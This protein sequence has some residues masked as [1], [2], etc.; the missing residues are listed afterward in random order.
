MLP[1][2]RSARL[3]A[4]VTTTTTIVSVKEE[5][6]TVTVAK[7]E[8]E[9]SKKSAKKSVSVSIKEEEDIQED[10]ENIEPIPLVANIDPTYLAHIPPGPC[11]LSWTHHSAS[12]ERCG[13]S[14]KVC[15]GVDEAGRGP[16]LGPMVYAVAYMPVDMKDD[17]A[18]VGFADS[19][20]LKE[21]Q[22]DK[23]FGTLQ[24][25][26]DWI[27][28]AVRVCS[29]QDISE[30]MLR[31]CKHN[32]NELAHETTMDLIAETLQR[33]IN[34]AEVYVDTVGPPDSYK[35]KLQ[36]RFPQLRFTVAKKADSL[37]PCVSAASICAKVTRDAVL[38]QWQYVEN[39]IETLFS[40][41]FGSGYPS[42]P[43]TVNWMNH[44]IDPVFGYPRIVRFSWATSV[45]LLKDRACAVKWPEE[46][47]AAEGADIRGYFGSKPTG[48]SSGDS[49]TT[50]AK[51]F[52]PRDTLLASLKHVAQFP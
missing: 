32:L 7:Q 8:L 20:L 24:D 45:N 51:A 39:N 16:V 29:P 50:L 34:V 33:G 6:S 9:G 37:Y 44:H 36:A 3:G 1:Q 28:W 17:L 47:E 26:N 11:T 23:L 5:I 2:R 10:R 19:K 13:E 40:N 43:N 15:L 35:R 30:A 14:M 18:N 52:P 12:P 49:G 31:R 4:N 48:G 42:D 22:R 27:G 38:K 41:P 21:E 25:H 46:E